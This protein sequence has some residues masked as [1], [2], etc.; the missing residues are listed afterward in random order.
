MLKK[1]SL[2][3]TSVSEPNS[4]LSTWADGCNNHEIDY[5]VIGDIASPAEFQLPGCDF[6]SI[7]RQRELP[8]RLARILPERHY[9]RK[10]LGY[11]LA[12]SRGVEVIIETDDDNIP[13]EGFWAKRTPMHRANLPQGQGWINVYRY[14]TDAL[15]WPRGFPLEFIHTNPPVNAIC[16]E[17]IFCPIQ[18]GLADGN[19]DVDAI[20][21]LV[22]PLPQHFSESPPVALGK[23]NWSPFNSQNT[24]WFPEAFPLLYLPSFCSFRM[25]DIWRSFV[26]SRICWENDWAVLFHGPTVFQK[27]NI[28]N[29]LKDLKDEVPGY[30]N[31]TLLCQELA[32]LDLLP[33][34]K[35][36]GKNLMECYKLLIELNLIQPDELAL[37]EAWISDLESI[38]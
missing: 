5:I 8:W 22:M 4:A 30:I 21:R 6:W 12:I 33:G 28:H 23:G 14:F 19:P 27:R 24:T 29:L 37:I 2:V 15:I 17:E 13:L 32:R 10:N 11:L 16:E 20:Y 7:E 26:A 36:I 34:K 35:N 25:C 3:I 38:Q 1:T 18:Q 31:N 9:A